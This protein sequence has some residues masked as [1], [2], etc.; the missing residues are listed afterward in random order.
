MTLKIKIHNPVHPPA[1]RKE[2]KIFNDEIFKDLSKYKATMVF[3]MSLRNLKELT[4]K[5]QL[6]AIKIERERLTDL[7][8]GSISMFCCST[9]RI[10]YTCDCPVLPG[11]DALFFSGKSL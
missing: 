2:K 8:A 11:G 3:Y 4:A 10:I 7:F 9:I 1:R 6:A 5:S